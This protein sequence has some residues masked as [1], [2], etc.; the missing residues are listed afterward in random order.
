MTGPEGRKSHRTID[1]LKYLNRVLA[2]QFAV[3]P[4]FTSVTVTLVDPT[5]LA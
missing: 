3:W 4:I 2:A 1:E 5:A